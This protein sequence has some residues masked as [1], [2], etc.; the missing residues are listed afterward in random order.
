[1]NESDLHV[2]IGN[3]EYPVLS[4]SRS[5]RDLGSPA[6]HNLSLGWEAPFAGS[7]N[8]VLCDAGQTRQIRVLSARF[9]NGAQQLAFLLED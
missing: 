9:R 7:Q 6:I 1:M 4:A 5:L 8:V 3:R 2:V